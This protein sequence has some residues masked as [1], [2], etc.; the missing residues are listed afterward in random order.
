MI[1][2][3]FKDKEGSMK[4]YIGFSLL[5]SICSATI[6]TIQVNAVIKQT[7]QGIAANPVLWGFWS[8]IVMYALAIA[9]AV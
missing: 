7:V 3:P 2:Q 8:F 6:V 9:F 1:K 4:F 5:L